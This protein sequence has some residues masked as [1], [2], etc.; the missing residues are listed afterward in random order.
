MTTWGR[1]RQLLS[2]NRE[3]TSTEKLIL[4]NDTN[5]LGMDTVMPEYT[6]VKNVPGLTQKHLS[7]LMIARQNLAMSLSFSITW[8]ASAL[9]SACSRTSPV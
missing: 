2:N 1:V 9:V 7:R 8:V 6:P 5:T 3:V 4:M